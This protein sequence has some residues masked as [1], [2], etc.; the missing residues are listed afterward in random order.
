MEPISRIKKKKN[1][2]K[3]QNFEKYN[4]ENFESIKDKLRI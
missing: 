4:H 2:V 1:R 3:K